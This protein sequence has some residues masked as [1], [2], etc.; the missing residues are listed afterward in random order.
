[1]PKRGNPNWK[2]GK[3]PEGAK[4]WKPGQSGNAKGRISAG[5]SILEHVNSLA[6][7]KPTEDK[8]RAIARNKKVDVIRRAAAERL[9]RLIEAPDMADFEDVAD[10]ISSLRSARASGLNTEAIKKV[11]VR[12]RT[13]PV[14]DG[15]PET[16]VEREIELFD[17]AGADFDRIMDRT[18]GRPVQALEH[19]GTVDSVVKVIKGVSMDD[20]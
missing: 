9:L 4:P 5:A 2:K 12:T 10:G 19:S 11:K 8:L 20:I 17:R 1:M 13:I 16:E 18:E 7:A 6:H 15:E 14:K 3:T